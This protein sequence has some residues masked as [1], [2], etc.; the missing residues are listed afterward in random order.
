MRFWMSLLTFALVVAC[1]PAGPSYR[2]AQRDLIENR[3]E[4]AAAKLEQ[5]AQEHPN[6]SEIHLDLGEAYFKIARKALDEGND[7]VYLNYLAKAQGAVLRAAELDPSAPGPHTW[8]GIIAAY[9]SDLNRTLINLRNAQ[10]LQPMSPVAY[11]NLAETYVYM[12]KIS[13]ARRNLKKAR[14]L[15]SPPVYIE[16]IEVLAAW[17]TGDY[18]EARDLFDSA[19]ALNPEVVQVWN[20]APVATPINSFE[21]FTRFC[22]SHLAC[23]P[24]MENPCE[25]MNH[26]V[27]TRNVSAETIRQE[28]VLEMERRRRLQ[29]IYD[30]HRDLEITI[31]DPD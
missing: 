8:M 22:C 20:E 17:R 14:K 29:G 18:T 3:P 19:L 12:G 16:M 30:S 21:D 15:G 10:R 31:E 4:D 11:T 5:L 24:Y 9:Q 28:L 27:K 6:S 7:V 1:A 26:E 23:G 13:K 2:E 25:D